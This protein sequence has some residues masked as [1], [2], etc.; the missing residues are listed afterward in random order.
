MFNNRFVIHPSNLN[1]DTR[2]YRVMILLEI[3]QNK[4]N[5]V[6]HYMY[7][8]GSIFTEPYKCIPLLTLSYFII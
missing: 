6:E 3:P 7:C 8:K 4:G 1:K 2:D 5:S